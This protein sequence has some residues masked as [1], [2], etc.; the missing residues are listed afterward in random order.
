[1][2]QIIQ[3]VELER[4]LISPTNPRKH[5]PEGSIIEMAASLSSVGLIEPLVV[6]SNHNLPNGTGKLEIVCG[7]RRF[8]GALIAGLKSLLCIVK[9]LT[10][11]QMFDIQ[12]SENLH[13]EDVSALDEAD[14]FYS[15]MLRKKMNLEDISLKFGKTEE[16]IFNRMRLVN[17]TKEAKVYLENGVLP[18]TAAIK[19]STLSEALQKDAIKRTICINE[20]N[21]ENKFMFAGLKDLKSFFEN[22]VSMPLNLADFNPED[23]KLCPQAGNC[24]QCAKRTGAGLFKDFIDNDKCLDAACYKDK[25]I[26]HYQKLRDKLSKTIKQ[27]IVF[28]AKSYNG[29]KDFKALGEV[30]SI[31]DFNEVDQEKLTEK[32]KKDLHYAIFIGV[33]RHRSEDEQNIPHGWIKI[34]KRAEKAI[35]N[36]VEKV[37]QQKEKEKADKEALIKRLTDEILFEQFKEYGFKSISPHSSS[38]V[39]ADI[40]DSCVN[41]T[42]AMLL[43]IVRRYSLTLKISVLQDN[44][45]KDIELTKSFD[46]VLT[47]EMN[48]NTTHIFCHDA[49]S[50]LDP[51]K[52]MCLINELVFI[53]ALG[54]VERLEQFIQE[55]ELDP[56]AAKRDAALRAK[57]I[58]K[59]AKVL[60]D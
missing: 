37:D 7:E 12:V 53:D 58:A 27:P 22:N 56:K 40:M 39:A 19:I 2:E 28:C 21:G 47:D 43:D 45:W 48:F 46:G 26:A 24:T 32:E 60:Q 41:I 1:M 42:A 5:F 50:N 20:V 16:Y 55:F 44:E 23:A 3:D 10:D 17:L 29:E 49:V 35:K 51:K 52:M 31:I 57:A 8:R 6:R 54:N 14:A 4:L 59:E 38:L 25:Q 36:G 18:V 15:L 11:D 9:E 13:R 34:T 30:L 33:N